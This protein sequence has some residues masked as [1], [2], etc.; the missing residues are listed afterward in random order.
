MEN[1]HL[2]SGQ[3]Q[4][5]HVTLMSY[6]LEPVIWSH[7]TGQR[8]PCFDKCQLFITWM[9]NI[10][11]VHS[12]PRLHVSVKLLLTA[13]PGAWRGSRFRRGFFFKPRSIA[14]RFIALPSVY[15]FSFVCEQTR[16]PTPPIVMMSSSANDRPSLS[17][18]RHIPPQESFVQLAN[19]S[20]QTKM[21]AGEKGL[22]GQTWV[23]ILRGW[24]PGHGLVVGC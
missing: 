15:F 9:S 14:E 4:K 12:K 20:I 8:I 1:Q 24:T 18:F 3:L 16:T 22:F 10:R 19:L 5:K 13:R 21:A 17:S 2:V 7:D 23:K 6:K 11:E